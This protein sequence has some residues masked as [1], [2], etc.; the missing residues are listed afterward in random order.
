VSASTHS[1]VGDLE[2]VACKLVGL[3]SLSIRPSCLHVQSLIQTSETERVFPPCMTIDRH[4]DD[5]GLVVGL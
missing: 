3:Q 1:A 5:P 2:A 4:A